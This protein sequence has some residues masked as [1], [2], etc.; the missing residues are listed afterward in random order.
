MDL[1]KIDKYLVEAKIE[2]FDS[3]E[4]KKKYILIVHKSGVTR[5]AWTL[6]NP[7]GGSFGMAN[8][9]SK[10]AAI[11]SATYK[12]TYET[13]EDIRKQ[14]GLDLYTGNTDELKFEKT[15]KL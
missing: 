5:W 15:L 9:T 14:G 6:K 10:K 2:T 11:S 4:K 13:L 3:L 12:M 8:Y 7:L 1:N